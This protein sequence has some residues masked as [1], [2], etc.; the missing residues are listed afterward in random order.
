MIRN[1]ERPEFL[2]A[3]LQGLGATVLCLQLI[4]ADEAVASI[5]RYGREVLPALGG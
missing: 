5:E 3:Y 4:G 1:I 2:S